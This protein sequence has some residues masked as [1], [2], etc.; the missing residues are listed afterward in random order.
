MS[1]SNF[2]IS[3][4]AYKPNNPKIELEVEKRQRNKDPPAGQP[5]EVAQEVWHTEA[6]RPSIFILI[7]SHLLRLVLVFSAPFLPLIW[8]N[9]HFNTLASHPVS[10][11]LL[12]TSWKHRGGKH[13]RDNLK[14][15]QN[16]EFIEQ[17]VPVE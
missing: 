5:K 1:N 4:V 16:I 10:P 11:S 8:F 9:T 13:I 3:L 6:S 15:R 14:P 2:R 12:R 7:T 17:L